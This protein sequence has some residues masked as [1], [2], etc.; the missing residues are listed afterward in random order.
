MSNLQY[1]MTAD[2]KAMT[3]A[4]IEAAI[5]GLEICRRLLD[6]MPAGATLWDV[7]LAKF[8]RRDATAL[9]FMNAFEAAA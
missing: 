1:Y 6:D 4:D 3:A 8:H 9:D 7:A 2:P 5:S